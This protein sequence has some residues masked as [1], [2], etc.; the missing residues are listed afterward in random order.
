[1]RRYLRG[2]SQSQS[3]QADHQD[4]GALPLPPDNMPY[5]VV[6]AGRSVLDGSALHRQTEDPE[7][8][9]LLPVSASGSANFTPRPRRL[10][11]FTLPGAIE[12]TRKTQMRRGRDTTSWG[13]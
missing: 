4:G 8:Q 9:S 5:G 11:S 3:P 12:R 13:T 2:A 10:P 1:M 7:R 6:P